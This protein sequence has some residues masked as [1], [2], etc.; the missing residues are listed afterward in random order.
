MWRCCPLLRCSTLYYH[1][2]ENSLLF[3]PIL[4]EK[5]FFSAEVRAKQ[6]KE[7]SPL[8]FPNRDSPEYEEL[9]KFSCITQII[10]LTTNENE[11]QA[12]ITELEP[13]SNNFNH[14]VTFPTPGI[15]VG[16][17]GRNK[18]AVIKT[19]VGVSATQDIKDAIAKLPNAKFV[20]GVG[21][22]YAF[23]PSKYKLGD[24][25]V[26]KTISD[27][28]NSFAGNSDLHIDRGE[29]EVVRDLQKIFCDDLVLKEDFVVSNIVHVSQIHCGKYVSYPVL[30][31]NEKI[32]DQFQAAVPGV[33]AGE[34]EGGELLRLQQEGKIEGIIFIKGVIGYADG[35]TAKGWQFTAAKAALNYTKKKL[36]FYDDFI[37]GKPLFQTKSS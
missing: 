17:F 2:F 22:N 14:P 18:V 11:F 23:N 7:H 3:P 27:L 4:D 37:P 16:M 13:P 33:I 32:R 21:V 31:D 26:S 15:V 20:I 29:I 34:M 10:L 25:L 24:V 12:A 5:P 6:Y 36:N 28:K 8:P 35:T 1:L 30:A 9:R 19:G